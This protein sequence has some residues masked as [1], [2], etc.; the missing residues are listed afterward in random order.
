VFA[1]YDE[2]FNDV[3]GEAGSFDRK[4]KYLIA[5]AASLAAG[6]EP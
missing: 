6:C 1:K 2:F 3:Y 4:T 5:L